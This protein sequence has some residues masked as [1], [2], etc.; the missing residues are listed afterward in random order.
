[1]SHTLEGE[2]NSINLPESIPR[3]QETSALTQEKKTEDVKR[4]TDEKTENDLDSSMDSPETAKKSTFITDIPLYLVILAITLTP[5]LLF[6][7]TAIIAT[8]IPRITNEFN[9]LPNVD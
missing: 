5:L 7:D 6:L 3:S 8:A 2:N 1:M 4:E 9:S